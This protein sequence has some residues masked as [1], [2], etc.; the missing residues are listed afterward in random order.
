[1]N[2]NDPSKNWVVKVAPAAPAG[3][4][5]SPEWNVAPRDLQLV[6]GNRVLIS[7]DAG[8]TEFDIATGT[9]GAAIEAVGVGSAIFGD[10]ADGSFTL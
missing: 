4:E 5:R 7:N 8:F 1:V 9:A 2:E 3:V 10:E 6:G